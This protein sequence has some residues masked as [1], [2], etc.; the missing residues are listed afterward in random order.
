[1]SVRL[2]LEE[3]L[4]RK[5]G[6]VHSNWPA[7]R[8]TE[9][10]LARGE[11]MLAENGALVVKTGAFTGRSPLDK[12]VVSHP[13][14]EGEVWWGAVN[15]PVSPATFDQLLDRALAHLRERDIFVF[16]GYAGASPSERLGLRVVT[17]KAW[18]ALF[19]S[20][21]FIRP[22]VAELA[23]HRVDFTLINA[24]SLKAGGAEAG[25][26]SDVFVGIDFARRIALIL[27]TEYAGEMKK[28]IF[29][30]MNYLL[31]RKGI[32]TMHCSANVGADRD[33]ALF[34]GLSG[35]GKTTLSA[36]PARGLIG[37]DE[38]AWSDSGIFNIEGGCYAKCINLS[39]ESEPQIYDAIRFGSVLENVAVDPAS[40]R[41]DYTD[42]AITENTRATYPVEFIPHAVIPSVGPHPK[43]VIF[44]TADAFGVFPPIAKLTPD[45]AMYHYISG[46]TAKVAGTEAGVTE[47]KATFSPCFGGPFLPLHPMRY[48]KLLGERLSQH[49][50]SCWLVN[51]GWSGGPY[52][53]GNRMKIAVS[54]AVVSAALSGALDRA[55]FTPDPVFKLLIPDQ[56]PGVARELLQPRETWGDKS[57][58]DAKA[59]ELATLFKKNFEQYAAECSAEVRSAGP[60]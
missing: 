40:R 4:A 22:S 44:L 47:P 5:D 34:F 19:A 21:L 15:H 16:D 42:A 12:Y 11:G 14:T 32:L 51:T 29:S 55:R 31:P 18:H 27:G 3:L 59:R 10:A 8:L 37:D 38:T 57:A 48:A 9:T 52:G 23:R 20:T 41:I 13:S 26:R 50:A 2:G 45:L 35:T 1:M 60:E 7:A 25:L 46:Y 33:A 56:C 36:D 30:V 53:V 6:G 43:T 54:R 17:E 58:Y 39:R 49:G 24:G 28:T